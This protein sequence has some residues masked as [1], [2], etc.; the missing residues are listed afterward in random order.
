ML[1]NI[2]LSA[3][4][5]SCFRFQIVMLS[6]KHTGLL[7]SCFRFQIVMLLNKHTACMDVCI[8]RPASG[9]GAKEK[10][11]VSIPVMHRE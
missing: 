3:L 11:T 2:P 1:S 7:L 9:A 4:L 8:N 10:E 6:N 5:L